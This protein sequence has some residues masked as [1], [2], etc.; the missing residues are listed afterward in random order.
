MELQ[1]GGEL[2]HGGGEAVVPDVLTQAAQEEQQRRQE[3]AEAEAA[4]AAATLP[5]QRQKTNRTRLE[6]FS[7]LWE[8]CWDRAAA[9]RQ[10]T[11]GFLF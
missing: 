3:A 10:A 8:T 4:A 6:M 1:L 9:C 2:G 11:T 7:Y 5:L